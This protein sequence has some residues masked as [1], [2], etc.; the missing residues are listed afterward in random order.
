M[1]WL[2]RRRIACGA[3]HDQADCAAVKDA[4]GDSKESL[5]AEEGH[6]SRG[7]RSCLAGGN[8]LPA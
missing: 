4:S 2:Q 8:E 5:L 7:D 3:F 1:I 6:P